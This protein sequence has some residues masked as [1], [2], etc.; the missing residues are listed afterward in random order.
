MK[1]PKPLILAMTASPGNT[2]ES[3]YVICSNLFAQH[4]EYRSEN[5]PDVRPYL[6][7]IHV[8]KVEVKLPE[9][10][11]EISGIIGEMQKELIKELQGYGFLRDKSLM[12]FIVV[13]CWSLEN[14]LIES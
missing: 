4:I 3:I 2:K 9:E 7:P 11:M 6:H 13:V 5:D 8:E 1:A 12:K 14:R 10:Y